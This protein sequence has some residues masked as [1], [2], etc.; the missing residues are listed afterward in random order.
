MH[1]RTCGDELPEAATFCVACGAS[2]QQHTAS[3]ISRPVPAATGRT[4]VLD[5]ARIPVTRVASPVLLAAPA[6]AGRTRAAG[7]CGRGARRTHALHSFPLFMLGIIL[8]VTTGNL[9]PGILVLLGITGAID[10]LN[11]GRVR[12]ALA[13]AV[14]L[15]GTAVLF[16]SGSIWPGI[17]IVLVIAALIERR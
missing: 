5:A 15:I 1:C 9:W 7:A 8:L 12:A 14:F 16:F 6:V 2:L 3:G 4:I 13:R 17:L 11:Q 10:E